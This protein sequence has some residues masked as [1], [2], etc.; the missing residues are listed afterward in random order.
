[1]KAI[2]EEEAGYVPL[3]K[4]Y[5]F[6]SR[7]EHFTRNLTI[8]EADSLLRTDLNRLC[9]LFRKSGKDCLLSLCHKRGLLLGCFSGFCLNIKRTS[10]RMIFVLCSAT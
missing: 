1:M 3:P 5:T 6:K 2:K 9:T 4:F 8:V 7:D 10:S